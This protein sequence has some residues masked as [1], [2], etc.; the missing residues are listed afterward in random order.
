MADRAARATSA[1]SS[2]ARWASSTSTPA[3]RAPATR[4]APLVAASASPTS[5]H[6]HD[7]ALRRRHYNGLQA[8]LKARAAQRACSASSYTLS[9]ATNYAGQRRR[10]PRHPDRTCRR[11]SATRGSAGFDRTPQPPDVSGSTTCPSAR[12]GAGPTAT[13]SR[14]PSSAAGRSTASS[15]IM[16]GTPIN[17]V[18]GTAGNLNAAGS[19]QYPDRV[20]A[21]G[22]IFPDNQEA[23]PRAGRGPT[24]PSTSTSTAPRSPRSTSPRASRSVSGRRRGTRSTARASG[25]WT[26]ASSGRSTLPRGVAASSS[27]SKR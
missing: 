1:R 22:A 10:N 4:G 6:Q 13:A 18:Q 27:A 26:S 15:A 9:K 5:G 14:A 24:R 8:E 12:T 11:R 19:G 7:P 3:L 2:T 20:K 23:A 25:T 16:S 21:L 17:I